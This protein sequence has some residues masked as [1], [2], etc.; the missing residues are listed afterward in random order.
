MNEKQCD[1]VATLREVRRQLTGFVLTDMQMVQSLIDKAESNELK[2]PASGY[3]LDFLSELIATGMD[4]I[5]NAITNQIKESEKH[6]MSQL[7]DQL[8]AIDTQVKQIKTSFDA[9]VATLANAPLP[10]DAQ[11]ALT[12]LQTDV[13]ALGTDVTAASAP[14][15]PATTGGSS[16]TGT[17]T[18]S[19]T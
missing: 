12:Q 14:A 3:K 7:G 17:T 16:G 18:T 11:A 2:S 8:T 10:P 6:I 15:A 9:F 19:A 5:L 1:L 13:G 4:K